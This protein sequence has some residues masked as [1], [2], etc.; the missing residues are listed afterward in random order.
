[1]LHYN[2]RVKIVTYKIFKAVGD[3]TKPEKGNML[4]KI[5]TRCN[6]AGYF[7]EQSYFKGGDKLSYQVVRRYDTNYNVTEE[8]KVQSVLQYLTPGDTKPDSL[9]IEK[10][11]FNY[12]LDGKGNKLEVKV[13]ENG[14]PWYKDINRLDDKGNIIEQ[15]EYVPWDTLNKIET[16]KYD[17]QGNIVERDWFH[18]DSTLINKY[19]YTYNDK[20]DITGLITYKTDGSISSTEIRRFDEKGNKIV[21]SCGKSDGAIVYNS[22]YK[23]TEFDAAGNWIKEVYY[24]NGKPESVTERV[25]EYYK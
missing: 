16:Y 3:S 13:L 20:G 17:A 14:K 10:D 22:R 8:D 25:I 2:G 9:S 12:K 5:I 4:S 15:K 23:F 21:D 18:A 6:E 1:M 24:A 7:V 19:I 11:S